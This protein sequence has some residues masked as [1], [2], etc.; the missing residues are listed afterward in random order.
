MMMHLDLLCCLSN[1]NTYPN[2]RPSY[3]RRRKR[4]FLANSLMHNRGLLPPPRNPAKQTATTASKKKIHLRPTF[5]G[6]SYCCHR[7]HSFHYSHAPCRVKCS[8]FSLKSGGIA[9]FHLRCNRVR[10]LCPESSQDVL[11]FFYGVAYFIA[12]ALMEG[13]HGIPRGR[14]FSLMMEGE[15]THSRSGAK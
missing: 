7:K 8:S 4:H 13:G 2:Y 12:V 1:P 10:L 6:L 15:G 11:G 14:L 9:L 5:I 3:M